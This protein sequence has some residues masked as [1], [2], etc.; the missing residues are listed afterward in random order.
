MSINQND[1]EKIAG[2]SQIAVSEDQA[3]ALSHDLTNILELVSKMDSIDTDSV[4]P[5]A[6]PFDATQ[7]L[8]HDQVSEKDQ[9]ELFQSIAPQTQSGLYIVP[10]VLET[11]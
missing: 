6:H 1:I 4:Q 9:R 3:S 8:R 2:L 5:L 7:P 11:E 10:K